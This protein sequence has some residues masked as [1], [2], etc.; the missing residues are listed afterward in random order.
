MTH[1][2]FSWMVALTT[3]AAW[4]SASELSFLHLPQLEWRD[5]QH[6][7]SLL[8]VVSCAGLL[9]SD[10]VE[11]EG[12]FIMSI[13]GQQ[14]QACCCTNTDHQD[15]ETRGKSHTRV[16]RLKCDHGGMSLQIT[17]SSMSS[18]LVILVSEQDHGRSYSLRVSNLFPGT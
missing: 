4:S 17:P 6:S 2:L 3:P 13:Y 9:G 5:A 16:R 12:D 18:D 15:G 14:Q 1:W 11:L 10:T 8:K 7:L